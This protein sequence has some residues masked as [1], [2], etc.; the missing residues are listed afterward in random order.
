VGLAVSGYLLL[1]PRPRR[2]DSLWLWLLLALFLSG[3][4]LCLR[5]LKMADSEHQAALQTLAEFSRE[6][7]EQSARLGAIYKVADALSEA[8]ELPELLGQGLERAVCAL[9]VDGGQIYL[10]S[11]GE[12]QVMRLSAIFGSDA[13]FWADEQTIRVGECIC[14]QAAAGCVPVVVGDVTNDPRV[15]GRACAAG[16]TPSVASVPLKTKGGS[17]GVL[18]VR[19]CDPHH[20]ALQ[21]I[22]LLTVIASF[23]AAA[24]EN[25][26]IRSEMQDRIVE[27]TAEVQ[28]LAIVQERER[29]GREMHD[30]LAQTLGL[31]NVQIEMVKGA[32]KAGDWVAAEGELTLLDT[33]L[34]HAYADV[35]Q[36]LDNLRHA[37]PQGETFIPT[38]QDTLHEFGRVNQLEADLVVENGNQPICFPPLVEVH[39]QRV[40][41][42]ALTNVRRHAAA[43]RVQVRILQNPGGWEVQVM[44]DGVGFDLACVDDGRGG[45]GLLTMR[46]RVESLGGRF[47]IDSQPKRGTRVAIFVPCDPGEE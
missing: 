38:L 10:V 35:R 4:G 40:I 16:G 42:E 1:A 33:Y 44:D 15:T 30:G 18:T 17:L 43:N 9:G 19:S 27:L 24:I 29:I 22:E 3:G 37:A 39:L 28:Q 8:V 45:Y 2:L 36:S 47:S 46:E 20:F 5:S 12:E 7:D 25:A 41:Q 23:M 34:G 21:D 32:A 6:L 13:H 11:D 31:L 26:R 14:G